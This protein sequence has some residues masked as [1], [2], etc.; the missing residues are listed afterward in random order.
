[1]NVRLSGL[2]FEPHAIALE[3]ERAIDKTL[4]YGVDL[5]GQRTPVDTGNLKSRLD[6]ED[7]QNG[8]SIFS[9]VHYSIFVEQGTRYFSGSFMFENAVPPIEREFQA[10]I[11]EVFK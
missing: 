5:V 10:N 3:L 8:G 7:E 4:A 11:I 6:S 2:L 1:M 9:D